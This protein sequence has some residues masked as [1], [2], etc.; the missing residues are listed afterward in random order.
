MRPRWL[1]RLINFLRGRDPVAEYYAWLANYGR[2]TEGRILDAEQDDDGTT[3]YYSYKIANVDYQTS[4]KLKPDQTDNRQRF[5]PGR[6]V[7]VR[8]DPKNPG[9]SIVP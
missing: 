8:F 9:R 1:S 3:I 2:I 5:Q 6:S 7:T 4:Q